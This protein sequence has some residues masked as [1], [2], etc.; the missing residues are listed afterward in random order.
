M[1]HSSP[2]AAP[3]S[4][5]ARETRARSAAEELTKAGTA[6]R[7]DGVIHVPEDE[8]C[9]FMF[10]APS[11]REAALVAQRAELDAFRVVEAVT[12][13]R[14]KHVQASQLEG[15]ARSVVL[16]AVVALTALGAPAIAR[17]DAVTQ[18]N[19][20][21]SN[22]LFVTA[23]QAPQASVPH[24]AMVHGAIYDAVNAIDRGHEGYLLTSRVARRSTPR[25]LRRRRRRTA[26]C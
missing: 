7:F 3:E 4:A 11:S 14:S 23:G 24:L 19:V 17:A 2:A 6:V 22:A 26:F 10:G 20:N 21:A 16:I 15:R 18:W 1:R 5:P 12:S 8:I 25:T 13:E 9:F